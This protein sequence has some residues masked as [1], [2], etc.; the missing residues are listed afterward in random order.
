MQAKRVIG[1]PFVKGDPR[2]D[3]RGGSRG[4]GRYR[5]IHREQCRQLVEKLKIREFFGDVTSG[6]AVDFSMTMGGKVVKVPAS[7]RNRLFAGLQL[8]EQGHGK[9]SQDVV[10]SFSPEVIEA[11]ERGLS[12]LLQKHVPKVCA[13][14]GS[15]LKMS[16]E[17][18]NDLIKLSALLD[19]AAEGVDA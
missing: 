13:A 14:C 1:R 2:I 5:E 19:P 17:L 16:P 18:A 3:R 9:A 8:I 10:H 6:R 4:G 11:F 12:A 7:L 15:H